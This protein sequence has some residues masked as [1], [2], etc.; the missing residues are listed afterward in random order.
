MTVRRLSLL[1]VVLVV[2]GLLPARASAPSGSSVPTPTL[3]APPAGARG[4]PLWDSY[5]DLAP[6]GYEEREYFVSGQ[7]TNAAGQ[8]QPYTTRIIVTRPTAASGKFNG[9][10]VLD[11]VNVTAQ[12]ENAVDT[13]EARELLMREGF[14]YVHVSAQA[15]GIC[16]TPLTPKVWDPARYGALSHPGDEWA[17][18]IFSQIAKAFRDP[19][20]PVAAGVERVLAV[21]Q[22]QSG[23]R[24]YGYVNDWLR[25]HPDHVGLI[26]AFLVHGAA[27]ST[28]RFDWRLPPDVRVLHLLSD[29]EAAPAPPTDDPG[30]RLW[31]IAATAHSDFFI[32][33]QSVFGHGP[34]VLGGAPKLS[35]P[36]YDALIDAAGNYGEQLHPMLA[37]CTL[38]GASMPMRYS[39]SAAIHHLA[40]W[41]RGGPGL[42]PPNGP[43]YLFDA[44]GQLAKDDV[45]NARGGIRLP[46]ADV[47]V[48]RYETTTCN[49]GGI[50]VP[51][52]DAQIRE[53]YPTHDDYVS[54]MRARADAAVAAGWLLPADAVDLMRRACRANNRWGTPAAAECSS[55]PRLSV[56]D[57]RIVDDAGRTVLLRGMNV[58]Q[59]GDYSQGAADVPP[60]LPFS[61]ADVE[62]IAALG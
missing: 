34:R 7:A 11:W 62:Q 4:F 36:E 61:R 9:T 40:A 52:T 25:T 38:A 20:T 17:F 16:C 15:A 41:A 43:R 5:Y 47:P 32:G 50:T 53:R 30:Y 51:F 58:N 8:V 60:V 46:P 31:E 55:R 39:V 48:A 49:L 14:A 18:D 26:D 57:G 37:T 1:A 56:R 44:S 10:V 54:R 29:R 23:S 35:K 24:L 19:A 45:G 33:Y 3:T 27:A 59:L 13:M 42:A 22:S 2:A 28:K 6:F 21:G 12:F